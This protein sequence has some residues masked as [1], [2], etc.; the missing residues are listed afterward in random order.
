VECNGGREVYRQVR[1]APLFLSI[2]NGTGRGEAACGSPTSTTLAG[3][4]PYIAV[5]PSLEAE[6]LRTRGNLSGNVCIW[7]EAREEIIEVRL[8]PRR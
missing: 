2:I 4:T 1:D 5:I 6:R 8:I 7:G 3:F